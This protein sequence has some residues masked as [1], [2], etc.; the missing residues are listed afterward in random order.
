MLPETAESLQTLVNL[1]QETV[2][3]HLEAWQSAQ[4][5]RLKHLQFQLTEM[6]LGVVVEALARMLPEA[7]LKQGD[8]PNIRGTAL[9]LMCRGFLH[10][11]GLP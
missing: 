9:Y 10:Q 7:R 4:A 2:A 3:E 5:A 8:S 11:T 1:G 6:Q